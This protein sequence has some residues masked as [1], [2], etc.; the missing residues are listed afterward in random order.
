MWRRC[1]KAL[2]NLKDID[3]GIQLLYTYD[4]VSQ[5]SLKIQLFFLSI[6]YS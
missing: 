2:E 1:E 5:K 3:I 4:G 6:I